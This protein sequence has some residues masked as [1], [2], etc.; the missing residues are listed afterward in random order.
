[1]QEYASD[2]GQ[3]AGLQRDLDTRHEHVLLENMSVMNTCLS[4]EK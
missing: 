1:M 2:Y 4:W 3:L